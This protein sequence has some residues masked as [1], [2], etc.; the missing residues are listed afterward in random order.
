MQ[1][2]EF[3]IWDEDNG[4]YWDFDQ[5]IDLLC[6]SGLKPSTSYQK[7][8]SDKDLGIYIDT[9]NKLGHRNSLIA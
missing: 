7:W 2:S 3:C 5:I 1:E 9:I 4:Y 6:K 8:C